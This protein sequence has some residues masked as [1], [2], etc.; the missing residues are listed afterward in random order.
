MKAP[1][2]VSRRNVLALSAAAGLSGAVGF[3]AVLRAEPQVLKTTGFG[4]PWQD[5]MTKELIPDFEREH[6]CRVQFDF[7]YGSWVAK[8]QSSPRSHPVFDVF[9]ANGN[10]QWIAA[11]RGLV[12]PTLDAKKVPNL[13]DVYAY[14]KSKAVVGVDG[15][16]MAIG[17]SY[18]KDKVSQPPTSWRDYWDTQYAGARGGYTI[19]THAFGQQIVMLAGQ[20][21]G[22]GPQDLD[23]AYKALERLKPIKLTNYGTAM[24]KMLLSGEIS[25]C[26][27][28]DGNAYRYNEENIGFVVPKEGGLIN[29]Q[30]YSITSGTKVRD[31][32]HAYINF[33]LSPRVQKR[34]SE[35]L[36][37]GPVNRTVKLDDKYQGKVITSEQQV[38]TL[39]KTDWGWY[40]AEKP[41]IDA[42]VNRIFGS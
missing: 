8:L 15:F 40:N 35:G 28:N 38:D 4:G 12:E 20:L 7:A 37:N 9:H 41:K 5:I 33:I 26:P 25:I 23:A 22:N 21:Y 39:I 18:R 34:I 19:P 17:L 24:M 1:K 3:P 6:D 13:A 29:E 36:W 42:Q 14:A 16:I 27:I 32:A 30:A 11:K 2:A 31:L 10:E